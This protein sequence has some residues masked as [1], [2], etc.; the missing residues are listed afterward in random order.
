MPATAPPSYTLTLPIKHLIKRAPLFIAPDATAREAARAMQHARVGS[1]LVR[2]EPPGI[3]TDRDLRGKIVAAALTADTPVQQ[4]MTRPLKT[5]D[6]DSMAFSALRLM[7]DENLHHLP[8]VEE[9]QIIG[10]ISASDLLIQEG[11][12]PLYLRAIMSDIEE[13]A[14]LARYGQEVTKLVQA[15]V[16]GGLSALHISQLVSSLNDALVR[17]LAQLAERFLGP[18]PTPF[19]W[20]VFGSEGRLEQTLLTD[21]DNAIVYGEQSPAAQSYF[22][23]LARHVVENLILVGFPSC[24]GGFMATRW[25]KPL[26]EWQTLFTRWLRLPEPEALLDTAI[27]F[28]FRAAAGELSLASLDDLVAGARDEKLFLV[29][30]ARGALSFRPPLGYF[31][32][33]RSE[34]GKVD[35]KTGGIAPIV[36]LAR[37]AALAAG[38][39]ERST[40]ERLAAA[41]ASAAVLSSQDATM[42]AEIFPFLFQLRVTQ[43]LRSIESGAAVDHS[44]P[45][46]G[47]STRERRHLK[48]SF[49]AIR[50]IQDGLRAAWRLDQLA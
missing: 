34:R 50:R 7:L 26:Q 3:V 43:Q 19:A 1:I 42:L 45:L 15:L 48:E 40:L 29:H 36:A 16:R 5:I 6:S 23:A 38:S 4:I 14:K 30:M 8:V 44:L 39:R 22:T 9:G 12:N 21:Q 32:R 28:D 24:A 37:V 10:V 47:L 17:R 35:L 46:A 18:P 41:K 31:N 11:N 49:V 27:F 2:A 25:C 20:I 13:P 33:L